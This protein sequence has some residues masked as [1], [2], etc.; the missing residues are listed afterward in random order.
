MEP[1]RRVHSP[2]GH[3]GREGPSKPYKNAYA[4][5]VQKHHSGRFRSYLN[6][7]AQK[8]QLEEN[9][10]QDSDSAAEPSPKR[11]LAREAPVKNGMKPARAPPAG[12]LQSIQPDLRSFEGL[13]SSKEDT[14]VNRQQQPHPGDPGAGK[15]EEEEEDEKE[16]AAEE[17]VPSNRPGGPLIFLKTWPVPGGQETLSRLVVSQQKASKSGERNK[18]EHGRNQGGSPPTP[19]DGT[20]DCPPAGQLSVELPSASAGFLSPRPMYGELMVSQMVA[21]HGSVVW[22]EEEP[23]WRLAPLSPGLHLVVA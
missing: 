7:I 16:A 10:L 14:S 11:G 1:Q 20:G 13:R 22:V 8:L 15:N 21:S 17:D 6:H 9:L 5:L 3:G 12:S 2:A 4:R 19:V 23:G 18:E